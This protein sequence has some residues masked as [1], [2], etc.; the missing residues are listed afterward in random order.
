MLPPGGFV[1]FDE[2][3]F[4]TGAQHFTLSS[5]G[6]EVYVFSGDPVTENLT[7][8]YH[9]FDF[10]PAESGRSFGRY[11][12][13]TGDDQFPPQLTTTLG[14]SNAGP[15]V[16]PIVI[17]EIH[18]RPWDIIMNGF[19]N[20]N[21]L[22]EYIE[23]HNIT[24]TNVPLYDPNHPANTWGLDNGVQYTFPLGVVL[25]PN[26]YLLVVNFDPADATQAAVFRAHN[27]VPANLPLYG[28]YGGKLDNGGEAV[29]LR[30]P[31]NPEPA[32]PPNFGLVPSLLV[33]RIHYS[34]SP[35]WPTNADGLGATLQRLVDSAYG[36]DP[37][38]WAAAGGTPGGP[39]IGGPPPQITVQPVN[40][41]VYVSYDGDFAVQA[42]GANLRYQWLFKGHPIQDAT[43]ST[44]HLSYVELP[45]GGEYSVVVL[46]GGG[47]TASSNAV[48]TV[49]TNAAVIVVQPQS[50][51][52]PLTNA[53]TI[54]A[55]IST[56]G[57]VSYQWFF[58]GVAIPGANA[59]NYTIASVG[60]TNAGTYWLRISDATASI[61]TRPATL[62]VTVPP[63]FVVLPQSQY[64]PTNG[65]AT[66]SVVVT[67][68][69]TLPITYR[70]RRIGGG[71]QTNID[72]YATTDFFTV[73]NVTS[74][75]RYDVIVFNVARPNGIQ[76]TP[77]IF[78][79][80]LPDTDH[81]GFDA[82]QL[83]LPGRLAVC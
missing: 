14:A 22:D 49:L 42:S 7:G 8:Y 82:H 74:S 5:L 24:S 50:V 67:N 45:A 66:V 78:I 46:G 27:Y 37:T 16:G 47:R 68:N 65:S 57:P 62:T 60:L 23:L 11:V 15:L 34:D 13:S 30:R 75:N 61:F 39:F 59:T 18:Y 69:A 1:V 36:N 72:I 53:A 79:A 63:L 35:P 54:S 81:D 21:S 2:T 76:M 38:N 58:N 29:E 43:N 41:S 56:A 26:G 33:E 44:F 32:G 83:P 71:G 3:Q 25:P 20:D 48:L 28:P 73:T 70:W 55:T 77:P 12:N 19:T 52:V 17:S 4:N 6:E 10:G 64:V 51:V 80:P 40:I 31:G 9:G